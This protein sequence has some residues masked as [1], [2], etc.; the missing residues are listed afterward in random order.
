MVASR[1]CSSMSQRV[2]LIVF[3]VAVV[4]VVVLFLLLGEGGG[5][6]CILFALSVVFK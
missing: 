5:Y 2:S 1:I 3:V 6:L 4:V